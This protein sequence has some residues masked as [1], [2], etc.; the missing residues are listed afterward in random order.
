MVGEDECRAVSKYLEVNGPLTLDELEESMD[1][2]RPTL[3]KATSLLLYSD[4]IACNIADGD[5][6]YQ[7]HV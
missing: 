2:K 4:E 5:L 3:R 6:Y 1:Y 7:N